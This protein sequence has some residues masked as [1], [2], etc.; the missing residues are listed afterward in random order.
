MPV[1][2]VIDGKELNECNRE[3][4]IP[5]YDLKINIEPGKQTIEFTPKETGVVPW[6]CWMGM[7]PGTFIIVENKLTA[8]RIKQVQ[9]ASPEEIPA[10]ETDRQ[11]LI[12]EFKKIWRRL[13]S[14]IEEHWSPV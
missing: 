9:P 14:T 12:R 1:K 4:V 11:R 10:T 3:I 8:D 5:Q 13:I 2:W 6:S 7:M